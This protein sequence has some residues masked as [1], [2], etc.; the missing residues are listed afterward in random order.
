MCAHTHS[1]EIHK[2]FLKSIYV[3]TPSLGLL[4]FSCFLD[5]QRGLC[6][7]PSP[8]KLSPLVSP[9]ISECTP[10]L[11]QQQ[12]ISTAVISHAVTILCK[13]YFTSPHTFPVHDGC[14]HVC[15]V[16]L[17]SE[18]QAWRTTRAPTIVLDGCT[19]FLLTGNT[20]WQ[21]HVYPS[22]HNLSKLQI[23]FCNRCNSKANGTK[24]K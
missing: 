9:S 3:L 10:G 23:E 12:L 11:S 6:T 4:G 20:H 14:Y 24:N 7:W 1:I 16:Q 17:Y 13:Q 8:S 15:H 21:D 19:R 2:Y 18:P 22:N 5:R